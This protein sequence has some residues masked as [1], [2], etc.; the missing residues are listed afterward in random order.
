[1]LAGRPRNAWLSRIAATALLAAGA[2]SV[3]L[4]S[5]YNE[6][7]Y[8]GAQSLEEDFVRFAAVMQTAAGT[9]EANYSKVQG[10]YADF[11]A[12]LAVL[13]RRSEAAPGVV[14]CDRALQ[15]SRQVG[16]RIAGPVPASAAQRVSDQ[17]FKGASCTTILIG[18]AQDQIERLRSQHQQRCGPDK[19]AILC[20]TLFGSPPIDGIF[21]VGTGAAPTDGLLPSAVAISLDELVGSQ[22]DVK[23]PRS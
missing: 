4:A 11:A 9:S 7:V 23:P 1:V 16:G 13:R 8:R 10:N 20:T 14:P 17:A 22:E 18:I 15:L 6:T 21:A 19:P 2:C 5:P 12:R 3:Q